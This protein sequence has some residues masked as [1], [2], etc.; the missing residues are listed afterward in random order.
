MVFDF[1]DTVQIQ[2]REKDPLIAKVKLQKMLSLHLADH[3]MTL[4]M[5]SNRTAPRDVLSGATLDFPRG[6]QPYPLRHKKLVMTQLAARAGAVLH[7][8][9][10]TKATS[11]NN[12]VFKFALDMR[13]NP[14]LGDYRR[15]RVARK[16]LDKMGSCPNLAAHSGRNSQGNNPSKGGR[17][18]INCIRGGKNLPTQRSGCNPDQTNKWQRFCGRIRGVPGASDC[19]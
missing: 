11:M 8:I 17:C 18:L 2:D 19:A 6:I 3:I 10:N 12:D 14:V 1:C 15:L 5:G 13:Y 9:A 4:R 7:N 16:E